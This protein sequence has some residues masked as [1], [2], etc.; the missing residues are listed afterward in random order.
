MRFSNRQLSEQ[1]F[2]FV[3]MV[4]LLVMQEPLLFIVQIIL[5]VLIVLRLSA[6]H[7]LTHLLPVITT[8]R[9]QNIGATLLMVLVAAF[10]FQVGVLNATVNLLACGTVMYF[11]TMLYSEENLVATLKDFNKGRG[12]AKSKI[13]H[14]QARKVSSSSLFKHFLSLVLLLAAGFIYD[15]SL[16]N[17]ALYFTLLMVAFF[18]LLLSLNSA[19]ALSHGAKLIVA[20]T[21][22]ALPIVG[23]LFF[24]VPNLPPFW[25]MPE[26]AVATTGLSEEM[27]PGDIAQ[28][29][30]ST[31]MAFRAEFERGTQNVPANLYWRAMV[32]EQFDGK[33]WRIDDKRKAVDNFKK[34]SPLSEAS[35]DFI[36][37]IIIE[38]HQQNW[39]YGLKNSIPLS[40]GIYQGL[41]GSLA[42]PVKVSKPLKYSLALPNSHAQ[43]SELGETKFAQVGQQELTEFDRQL[44]LAFDSSLHPQTQAIANRLWQQA[45]EQITQNADR[46]MQ[47]AA[48][49][50]DLVLNYFNQNRFQ[51]SLS[52]PL[53]VGDH[54]DDF[55]LNTRVGFCAH[56]ASAYTLAMRMQ[57]I[58]ARVVTG[59]LGGEY[60]PLGQ[61]Y[62]VYDADAHAWSEYWVERE[63]GNGYWQRVDPTAVVSPIRIESGIEQAVN[64]DVTLVELPM[65]LAK[66]VAWLNALRQQFQSLDYYWTTQFLD[67]DYKAQQD[68]YKKLFKDTIDVMIFAVILCTVVLLPAVVLILMERVKKYQNVSWQ[69]RVLTR[70]AKMLAYKHKSQNS[71]KK[72]TR[73]PHWTLS[74]YQSFLVKQLPENSDKLNRLFAIITHAMYRLDSTGSDKPSAEQR[75]AVDEII[76]SL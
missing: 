2:A 65:Q 64:R 18:A 23:A 4:L 44:N 15:V 1:L 45:T 38:P 40:D 28:L 51:Y 17:A 69:Q 26:K 50:S 55:M 8:M 29:V 36:Y 57:G 10:S 30:K 47:V 72:F 25:K 33:T 43:E 6:S 76:K 31:R 49:Y 7:K 34:P 14:K 22:I 13:K 27:S 24:I 58:P 5:I 74:E 71:E 9:V 73:E 37:S 39:L 60:N 3:Q 61:Y 12:K 19:L 62:T 11:F 46:N 32:L 53:L 54:I 66:S 75:K 35:R 21:L 63:D 42:R 48:R 56:F 67:F 70:L 41:D 68:L 52:P 20:H 16:L 59:Y